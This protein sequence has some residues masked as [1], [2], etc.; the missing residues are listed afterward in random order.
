MLAA[1]A[2]L[3]AIDLSGL[4]VVAGP[5]AGGTVAQATSRRATREKTDRMKNPLKN[6]VDG[7]REKVYTDRPAIVWSSHTEPAKHG[8]GTQNGRIVLVHEMN[9][10]GSLEV[11][12]AR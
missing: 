5:A 1:P 4:L 6:R 10:A 9:Q 7:W 2:V 8:E 3:E 11:R 12:E